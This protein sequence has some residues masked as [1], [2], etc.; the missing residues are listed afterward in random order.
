MSQEKCSQTN[1][2]LNLILKTKQIEE[3]HNN[4]QVLSEKESILSGNIKTGYSVNFPPAKTC[5]LSATKVCSQVCYAANPGKPITWKH[6]IAKQLR[7]F[8]YFMN[9]PVKTIGDRILREIQGKQNWLRWNGSGDLFGKSV[10]VINYI[11]EK[12]KSI[13]HCV[14]TRNPRLAKLIRQD[15]DNI[16]IGFSLDNTRKSRRRKQIM[17]KFGHKR[18][19]YTYLR[20]NKGENTMGAAIVFNKQGGELHKEKYY[21]EDNGR[22][23]PVDAGLMKTKDACGKCRKCFSEKTLRLK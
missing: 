22:H 2:L 13:K 11:A 12:D 8:H 6:S 23:C 7:V 9:T 15:L 3:Y 20:T 21:K 4:T 14:I 17:D 10:R 1:F 16:F 18:L 19:Y 5:V